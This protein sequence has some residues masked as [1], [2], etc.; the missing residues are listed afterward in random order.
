ML[1]LIERSLVLSGK[2]GKRGGGLVGRGD[3]GA[4]AG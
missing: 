2:S 3:T 4:V 1:L